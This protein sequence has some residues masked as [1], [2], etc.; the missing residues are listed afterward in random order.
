MPLNDILF[1]P[2]ALRNITLPNR[3]VRSATYEG[4]GDANGMPQPEMADLYTRLARAGTGTIITGF[5]FISTE[6]RAMQPG[7]CGIDTNATINVWQ[8]LVHR[9]KTAAPNMRLI[10]QLAHTGRQTRT[11]STGHP[12]VG[13]SSRRC[14]YFREKVHPLLD[15]D[16][17]RIVS[18]FAA[19]ARRAQQ[20]GFD[21]V[22]VHAA[23]GYLI[24]QFLSPHT[25]I[26]PDAWAD[27]TRFL[28]AIVRAVK[29]TCGTTFPVFAKFSGADDRGLTVDDTI[30]HIRSV[31]SD[32]EAAEISY[33]TMEYGLNIIRGDWPV[34][35]AFEVNPLLQ[36]VPRPMRGLFRRFVL[37][38]VIKRRIPF[39]ENYNRAAATQIARAVNVPV[40]AVGGYRRAASLRAALS[41]NGLAAVSL[42]RPFL[43]EPDLAEI[44]RTNDNWCSPCT[45]CNVCTINCDAPLPVRCVQQ[46]KKANHE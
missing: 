26:R 13:A 29:S 16:I 46:Q 9:V 1:T 12:V 31:E 38:P 33:G 2:L 17:S 21:G 39:T 25:N 4:G 30:R 37:A 35:R 36:S 20:A 45:N 3:L 5:C 41:D 42:C 28:M 22:Q 11:T 18:D 43:C 8:S 44:L 32:I 27:G 24:H 7:Q 40:F 6:G 15:V 23:H 10:M 14:L 34:E 19:A